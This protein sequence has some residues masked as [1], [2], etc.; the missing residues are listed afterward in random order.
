MR[1]RAP[2]EDGNTDVE[3]TLLSDG[4]KHIER[5]KPFFFGCLQDEVFKIGAEADVV[6]IVWRGEGGGIVHSGEI[7]DLTAGEDG[8]PVGSNFHQVIEQAEAVDRILLQTEAQGFKFLIGLG[9]ESQ[10]P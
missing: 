2:A 3:Q 4:S 9:V 5:I 10:V 8:W 6:E 1:P 7:E